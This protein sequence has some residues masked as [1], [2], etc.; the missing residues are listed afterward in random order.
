MAGSNTGSSGGANNIGLVGNLI[1]KPLNS[2]A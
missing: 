2:G 1:A